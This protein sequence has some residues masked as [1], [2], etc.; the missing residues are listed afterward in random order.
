MNRFRFTAVDTTGRVS[1]GT[2][3]LDSEQEVLRAL[4]QQSLIPLKIEPISRGS[5]MR[6]PRWS[7]AVAR[8][9]FRQAD[10]LA[11]TRQLHSL[12]RA[13]LSVDKALGIVADIPS[14]SQMG[15]L[16]RELG[17][18]IREG[19][20]LSDALAGSDRLQ[21]LH[22][23]LGVLRAGEASGAVPDALSQIVTLQADRLSAGERLKSAL[24]YP[25]I[26]MA[27]VLISIG[28]IVGLV[29]PQFEAIFEEAGE[30]LPAATRVVM[31]MGEFLR[32]FSWLLFGGAAAGLLALKTW[33]ARPGVLEQV[34]ARSLRLPIVSSTAG[35]LET[36]RFARTLS[37]LVKGGLP[38]PQAFRIAGES[39]RNLKL[40]SAAAQARDVL[41]EGGDF[42]VLIG[43]GQG[44][45]PLLRQMVT[46]GLETGSLEVALR[47]TAEILESEAR[48]TIERWVA[49]AVPLT[50]IVMGLV[51]AAL[52]GSVMVGI[53]S[54]NELAG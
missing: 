3:T 33:L 11:F 35:K 9:P 21:A 25:A 44:F 12:L 50:T 14:T 16:A 42:V 29:L 10:T 8:R 41:A 20:Q 49:L 27:T 47:E 34:H 30:S 5:G 13:G 36:A 51:V 46:V 37:T 2:M 4:E 18:S 40:R 23:Y 6:L 26:L 28:L 43:P 22:P 48:T 1:A 38:L 54:V 31:G 39:L 15:A 53:L 17:R 24:V 52:I 32:E 7:E 19:S 45:S